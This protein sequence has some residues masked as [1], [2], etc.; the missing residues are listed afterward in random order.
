M[1]EVVVDQYGNLKD[2]IETVMVYGVALPSGLHP[3]ANIARANTALL[4]DAINTERKTGL[5]PRQLAEQRAELLW[6][7]QEMVEFFQPNACGSED[8]KRDALNGAFR[9]LNKIEAK[10]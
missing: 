3:K 1:Q 4:A 8:N 9:I 10:P 7:L 2:G 6:A 5:T